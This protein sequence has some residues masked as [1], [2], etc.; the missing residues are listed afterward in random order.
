[1]EM[2]G[3]SMSPQRATIGRNATQCLL[4]ITIILLT[5]AG[6]IF[7][8]QRVSKSRIAG[9]RYIEEFPVC[10]KGKGIR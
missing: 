8:S 7:I 10:P 2:M 9:Y 6:R 4:M 3:L 5:V 1:M